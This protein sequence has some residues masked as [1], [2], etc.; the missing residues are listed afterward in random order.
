LPVRVLLVDDESDLTSSLK[1]GLEHQGFRVDAY[2]DPTEALA[3]FRPGRYD[4][5]ILDIRMPKMD[6][7][8]LCK[9]IR[10]IDD[11]V[12]FC[13]FTAFEVYPREFDTMFPEMKVDAFLTKPMS[14]GDLSERLGGIMTGS[15]PASAAPNR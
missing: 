9:E 2:N 11:K 12:H 3:E 1:I 4:I 14:V 5:A 7:F 13:F 6:G 8:T 15:E 10:K